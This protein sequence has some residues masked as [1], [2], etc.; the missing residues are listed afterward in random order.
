MTYIR[1]NDTSLAE[2]SE[3]IVKK[4]ESELLTC[5]SI[6]EMIDV[7][8]EWFRR[9]CITSCFVVAKA[10]LLCIFTLMLALFLSQLYFITLV[11]THSFM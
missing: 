10:R 8:G 3:K 4:Y 7:I 2:S 6:T 11:F 1:N 5:E 9:L